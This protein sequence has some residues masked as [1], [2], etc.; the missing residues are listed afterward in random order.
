MSKNNNNNKNNNRTS[1]GICVKRKSKNELPP[2]LL[3]L[4]GGVQEAPVHV[5]V[6]ECV[7]VC[8]REYVCVRE[9]V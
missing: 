3:M 6:C 5:C 7:C 2:V 1:R 4:F 9:C 8:E